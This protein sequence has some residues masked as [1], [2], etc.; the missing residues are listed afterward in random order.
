MMDTA[1]QQD[2]R[3][4]L[5]IGRPGAPRSGFAR[6]IGQGASRRT[7]VVAVMLAAF[8]SGPTTEV[9]ADAAEA[10]ANPVRVLVTLPRRQS[11]SSSLSGTG[12]I[13]PQIQSAIAFQTNGRVTER[14]VEVGQH[15]TADQVL[16]RLDPTGQQ[17]DV[18][19]A[20]AALN[21][22]NARLRE[23]QVT[24]RRNADLLAKGFTPR[25]VFDQA[26]AALHSAEAQV[27]AAQASLKTAVEHLSYTDLRAR[28]DGIIVDRAVEVGQV[29][30]DGQAV[31]T[32]AEDGPRDAVFEVPEAAVVHPPTDN[33]VDL[34]LQAKP[35]ITAVGEV[36]E[37]SPILNQTSGTVTVK[38]GI[39]R[40]PAGMTLGAA[41]VGHG[42]WGERQGYVIPWSALFE[43]R[44]KPAVWILDQDDRVSLR[45][46]AID[47]YRTGAV[48][49]ASGVEDGDRVVATGVQWLYPGQR[50]AVAGLDNGGSP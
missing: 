20:E 32:V 10:N 29:V 4:A 24:F 49:L 40:T 41:V 39:A 28:R 42:R 36:R 2:R 43:D 22:A 19:S 5:A 3:A 9:P 46:V 16:A 26:E 13:A 37:I 48:V 45:S 8:V 30:L 25:A 34:S 17:A 31:F 44:G 7:A 1:K 14:L 21:S 15:V 18:A 23:A 27:T 50:V 6:V 38:V 47:E 35:E 11:I 12:T 33:T